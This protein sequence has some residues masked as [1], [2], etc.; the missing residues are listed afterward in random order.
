VN[1][2]HHCDTGVSVLPGQ[3]PKRR[4]GLDITEREVQG[5]VVIT[6]C[7]D[8]DMLTAPALAGAIEAAARHAPPAIVVDLS[9]VDFLASAGMSVLVSA[10]ENLTP[11]V[12]FGVV[13]SGPA[14]S[15]PLEVLG[16]DALIALYRTLDEACDDL[17]PPT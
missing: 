6:V 3:V 9:G 11:A 16:I 13:A 15:R 14:T 10:H 12:G 4:D 1:H 8:L 7:G 5:S 2:Q 17:R